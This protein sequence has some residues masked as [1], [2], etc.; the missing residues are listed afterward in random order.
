[1]SITI[2][3]SSDCHLALWDKDSFKIRKAASAGKEVLSALAVSNDG[4]YLGVGSISGSVSVYISFSLQKLY[5]VKEVH[6]I[7]VTGV[8]F[9]LCSE[10]TKAIVG[11][12][13]FNLISVSADNAIRLHQMP[14]IG[15]ILWIM[16]GAF[17][18]SF[19]TADSRAGYIMITAAPHLSTFPLYI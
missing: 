6:S 2:Q 4:V 18:L 14:V 15:C 1:M 3:R 13:D 5:H 16:V 12:R 19:L 8:D 7:F 10:T 9:L 17:L 11:L